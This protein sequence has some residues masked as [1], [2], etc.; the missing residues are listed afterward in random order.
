M[1]GPWRCLGCHKICDTPYLCKFHARVSRSQTCAAGRFEH[2]RPRP[3][4]Q[5]HQP[6]VHPPDQPAHPPAHPPPQPVPYVYPTTEHDWIHTFFRSWA[7][8][9]R[10]GARWTA[11]C[12][13]LPELAAW[14]SVAFDRLLDCWDP[15]F[16]GWLLQP[17]CPFNQGS[18]PLG[19]VSQHIPDEVLSMMLKRWALDNP[20][21]T[22]ADL[23]PLLFREANSAAARLV[24]QANAVVNDARLRA[25]LY[26]VGVV[27]RPFP[28]LNQPAPGGR[29]ARLVLPSYFHAPTVRSGCPGT[30]TGP[31]P[32]SCLS[33]DP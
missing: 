21:C 5:L 11:S 10:A 23:P 3:A 26:Q 15:D 28:P 30:G 16:R 19:A 25:A 18:P 14:P 22:L 20:R 27:Q 24:D 6:P 29:P 7:F 1:P 4:R 33:C 13:G 9:L 2:L 17:G 32:P 8:G 12:A 31:G